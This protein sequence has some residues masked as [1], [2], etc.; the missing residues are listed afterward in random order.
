[1]ERPV[2]PHSIL[3]RHFRFSRRKNQRW[4]KPRGVLR[5]ALRAVSEVETSQLH[6]GPDDWYAYWH[7]HLDWYGLGNLNPRIRLIFL[8]GYAKLFDRYAQQAPE[9]GKPYQLWISLTIHD[10]G[11]DAV[12][13]HTPNPHADF[14]ARLNHVNWDGTE[15]ERLFSTWLPGYRLIAYRDAYGIQISAEGH[16]DC[17]I[18]S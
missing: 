3:D 11:Q 10:A 18:G 15:I 9:L 7:H 5:R 1:M 6:T 17:L 12:F 16:G 14:P 2:P 13:L 4:K 8:E